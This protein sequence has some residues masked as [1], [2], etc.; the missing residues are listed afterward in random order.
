MPEHADLSAREHIACQLEL[1]YARLTRDHAGA[2]GSP[3]TSMRWS[4]RDLDVRLA[5]RRLAAGNSSEAANRRLARTLLALSTNTALQSVGRISLRLSQ[6]EPGLV[7]RGFHG[8]CGAGLRDWRN[9]QIVETRYRSITLV[10][11]DALARIA[12]APRRC[13]F[14]G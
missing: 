9:R 8:N 3:L 12:G 1:G 10:R 14:G 7:D 6:A 13:G 2:A 4:A 5:G 11:L